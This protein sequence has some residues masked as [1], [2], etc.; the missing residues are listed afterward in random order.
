M[1]DCDYGMTYENEREWYINEHE[2][3][4][5][6]IDVNEIP[7]SDLEDC[8]YKCLRVIDDLIVSQ[9]EEITKLK[10]MLK[11]LPND[12]DIFSWDEK[13]EMWRHDEDGISDEEEEE[14]E[15]EVEEESEEDS[16]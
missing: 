4:D 12:M 16:D 10:L 2:I 15:V 5:D 6:E 8:D 1:S 13:R 7:T 3:D 14:E 11:R 9:A